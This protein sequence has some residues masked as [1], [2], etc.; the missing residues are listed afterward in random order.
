MTNASKKALVDY[1]C[2]II[3][4]QRRELLQNILAQRTRHIR[5]YWKTST[6]RKMPV[7][8][9]APVNVLVYRHYNHRES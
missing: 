9:Y 4:Q 5:L 7:P 1:L 2:G 3:N 8:Y 6:S